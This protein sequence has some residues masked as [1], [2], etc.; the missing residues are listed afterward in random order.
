MMF[1]C[2]TRDS[3]LSLHVTVPLQCL[4]ICEH[5]GHVPSIAPLWWQ[6]IQ[7]CYPETIFL[8]DKMKHVTQEASIHC[9]CSDDPIVFNI[10]LDNKDELTLDFETMLAMLDIA[11]EHKLIS[12]LPDEWWLTVDQIYGEALNRTY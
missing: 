8:F 1:K 5:Q 2:V 7:H 6:N 11:D 10:L 12:P 3:T 9:E 4:A